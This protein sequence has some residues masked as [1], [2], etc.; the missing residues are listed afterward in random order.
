MAAVTLGEVVI[1][2]IIPSHPMLRHEYHHVKQ[3]Q[4]LGPF[5]LPA[6]LLGMVVGVVK[7][8][9]HRHNP[10]EQAAIKAAQGE[11]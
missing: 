2:T 7:G 9:W 8:H 1:C 5:F 10:L 6:Y 4:V 3:Y 11:K